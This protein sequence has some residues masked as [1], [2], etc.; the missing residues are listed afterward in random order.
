MTARW[1]SPETT[2]IDTGGHG[3]TNRTGNAVW[4]LEAERRGRS[5][6]GFG[7]AGSP[8][9]KAIGGSRHG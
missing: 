8:T 1:R 9:T 7:F 2:S 5:E 6:S 3:P 4:D